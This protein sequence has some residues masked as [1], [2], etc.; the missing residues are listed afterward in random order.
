MPKMKQTVETTIKA[1]LSP[2]LLPKIQEKL[3]VYRKAVAKAAE[4]KVAEKT[5][6]DDIETTVADAGEYEALEAG[7]VVDNIPMK[8]IGG[9]TSEFDKVAFLKH[10]KLP[11]DA[12]EKFTKK[13]PKA[14]Y[15]SVTLP[16]A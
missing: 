9:E 8:I 1:T 2:K 15:L 12:F 4:A 14:K 11:V 16:R 5:A 7:V 10:Y 13:K 6:K 3:K